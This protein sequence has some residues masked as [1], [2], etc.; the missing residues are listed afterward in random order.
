MLRELLDLALLE[1]FAHGLARACR[2]RVC[3]FDVTGQLV[4]ASPAASRFA[5]LTGHRPAVIPAHPKMTRV[6]AHD[7]PGSVAFIASG[8]VWYIVAPVY[9][10]RKRVGFVG[11]GEF[12]PPAP[13]ADQ[14]HHRDEPLVSDSEEVQRAWMGLARLQHA[15]NARPVVTARWA[16]R[17]LADRCRRESRVQSIAAELS[18]VGDI[19]ELL[20]GTLGL[21]TILDRI[22]AE[23]AR[24]MRCRFCTMRLYDPVTDELTLQAGHN[25]PKRYLNKG[26]LLRSESPIDHEALNGNIVY[27]EDVGRDSRFRYP[28]EARRAGMV[29]V[30]TAGMM[31]R[32]QPVGVL[33][34]YTDRRQ[35]F[36]RL[37][38]HLLRAVA[39]QAATAI[40]HAR[41]IEERLRNAETQRQ[42]ELAGDVQSRMVRIPPPH[43]PLLQ[44]AF[45]FQPSSHVG[46]DFCD[47]LTLGDGR[48]AAV[49][50]D[51]V[52]KGIPASL[53][54]ASVRGALR[55]TAEHTTD[56]G[57]LAMLVNRH[58]CRET[59]VSEFVTLA[60][61]A[62][63]P[64]A[65]RLGYCSAG[66]EPLLLL[67]NGQVEQVEEAGLVLGI[68]P[69]ERY[70]ESSL[71]L[72]PDDF[73]LLYTDGAVEAMNFEGELFGRERL[74]TAVQQY[75]SL[76]PEQT[77][78]NI[79]WDIRRF[80]GLAEQSDDLTLVGVRVSA[81]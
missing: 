3:I 29:S 23:T 21:Q 63:D 10:E 68:F 52:G 37:Q 27:I 71:A 32:N 80:A 56:L 61:V 59:L 8:P 78:R 62:F 69:E 28:E 43:H 72:Q 19:A 30:L 33:R 81:S 77:L 1:D 9:L 12:R 51:V 74:R 48:L 67:R 54:M 18:L 73:L 45:V 14:R 4:A 38:Q 22:V 53:Q 35:R 44:T 75:G 76:D 2:L 40:V 46:G 11:V 39:S 15:G 47:F 49:V 64:S 55:A 60:L 36:R 25:L 5:R 17:M 34:V 79:V 58:V 70:R 6:P 65:R 24:V 50:A 66:H 42:L 57:Q 16:A 20:S 13:G 41:L 31:Y 26:R 7:P